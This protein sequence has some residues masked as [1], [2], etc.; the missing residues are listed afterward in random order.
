MIYYPS[1]CPS[2]EIGDDWPT[3]SLAR[4]EREITQSASSEIVKTERGH[5]RELGQ[6]RG[7]E[8]EEEEEES[9]DGACYRI[10]SFRVLGTHNS[11]HL[12]TAI[13]FIPPLR[14]SHPGLIEQLD[15]FKFRALELDLHLIRDTI[16]VYHMQLYDDRSSCYC[17]R[18]CL[19]QIHLW[20]SSSPK[21]F[22]VYIF[23]ELKTAAFENLQSYTLGFGQTQL[24][25]IESQILEVFGREDLI[26]PQDIQ[27]DFDTM[28]ESLDA[29]G[30]AAWPLVEEARGKVMFLMLDS[31]DVLKSVYLQNS[32]SLRNVV[33]ACTHA[34]RPYS[35]CL[36][37]QSPA[38]TQ[39][40]SQRGILTRALSNVGTC[41]NW[42]PFF[43]KETYHTALA[44]KS[45]V[46][47]GDCVVCNTN[48]VSEYCES[49]PSGETVECI[50]Q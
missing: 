49:L 43:D 42:N 22:P 14:Y 9:H 27:G 20:S 6:W 36:T 46:F 26:L 32:T 4:K 15:R 10:S 48:D 45:N 7:R 37:E 39:I 25:L 8:E 17:F 2:I 40:L 21:H 35:A 50:W 19:E 18:E 3:S 30:P 1:Q 16:L 33:F 41:T 13:R 23:L 12:S 29:K 31:H 44:S 5:Q 34:V 47:M 24:D 38:K 11:Y 28:L